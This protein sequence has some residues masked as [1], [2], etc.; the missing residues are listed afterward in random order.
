MKRIM[1]QCDFNGKK[2]PHYIYVGD[3]NPKNHPLQHQ[4]AW[5][6]SERGGSIPPEVMAQVENL[7]KIAEEHQVSFEDLC[8]Y[9]MAGAHMMEQQHPNNPALAQTKMQTIGNQPAPGQQRPAPAS[10]S[11]LSENT[12]QAGQSANVPDSNS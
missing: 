12:T 2:A 7:R 5:L 10:Q 11:R 3:P 1:V 9:A 4:A 8:A 6:A